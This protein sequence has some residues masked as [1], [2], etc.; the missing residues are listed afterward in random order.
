M[1]N[2]IYETKDCV[3]GYLN[4]VLHREDGPTMK[5]AD[6]TKRWYLNGK[7]HR[8]EGPAVEFANGKRVWYLDGNLHRE[9]GPAVTHPDGY[10]QWWINGRKLDEEEFNQWLSKK[11]LHE[12]LQ[13]TLP[14][15]HIEKKKK[16]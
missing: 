15:K 9:D 8:V 12:K 11:A 4:D 1:K 10:K 3:G 2:G 16:I 5:D 6:G 13:S 14:E 7:R